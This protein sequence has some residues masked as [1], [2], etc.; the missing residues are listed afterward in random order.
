MNLLA[1]ILARFGYVKVSCPEA[2]IR[3]SE[4]QEDMLTQLVDATEGSNISNLFK[5]ALRQQRIIT[6][7]LR[8]IRAVSSKGG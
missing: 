6:G 8:S 1:R 4:Q 5:R 3:L 7:L 2:A